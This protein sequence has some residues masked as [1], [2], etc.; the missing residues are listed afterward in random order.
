MDASEHIPE[1]RLGTFIEALV[2]F[3]HDPRIS[4]MSRRKKFSTGLL[5]FSGK[6]GYLTGAQVTSGIEILTDYDLLRAVNA[7]LSP[8]FKKR[9]NLAC[10][11]V[12]LN[13]DL[14]DAFYRC[15][16]ENN[17]ERVRQPTRQQI[18]TY[19]GALTRKLIALRQDRDYF[20]LDLLDRVLDFLEPDQAHRVGNPIAL[21]YRIPNHGLRA[22]VETSFKEHEIA[23]SVIGTLKFEYI[24]LE[25]EKRQ[26]LPT[27]IL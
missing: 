17:K 10:D 14:F 5:L 19:R 26:T 13:N 9:Y 21:D 12:A 25:N 15:I 4:S 3:K 2:K 24:T 27:Y 7:A 16:A 11:S 18:S 8:D 20:T 22:V 6:E 1:E 23:K